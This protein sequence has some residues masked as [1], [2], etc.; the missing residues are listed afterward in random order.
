[1][2][3]P[4]HNHHCQLQKQVILKFKLTLLHKHRPRPII[5]CQLAIYSR[6]TPKW[7]GRYLKVP[8]AKSKEIGL[9]LNVGTGVKQK[10]DLHLLTNAVMVEVSEFDKWINRSHKHIVCDIL[11]YNFDLGL[12]NEIRYEFSSRTLSK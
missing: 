8:Y 2:C 9:E 5:I 6:P 11:D 3:S 12:Q 10:L 4:F 1:M 7:V